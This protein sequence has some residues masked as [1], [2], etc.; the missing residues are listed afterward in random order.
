MYA[1]QSSEPNGAHAASWPVL[2]IYPNI[3]IATYVISWIKTQGSELQGQEE[4]GRTRQMSEL[5][6]YT[7]HYSKPCIGSVNK[8]P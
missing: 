5:F 6:T 1:C 8:L 4:A 7:Y 3:N 2:I